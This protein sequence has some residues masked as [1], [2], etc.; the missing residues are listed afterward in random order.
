MPKILSPPPRDEDQTTGSL[1][2]G[3]GP[4]AGI[5]VLS[6]LVGVLIITSLAFASA[7]AS[8]AFVISSSTTPPL[9]DPTLTRSA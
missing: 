5:T 6:I 7:L 2:S 8:K 4:I 3:S 9:T 1:I